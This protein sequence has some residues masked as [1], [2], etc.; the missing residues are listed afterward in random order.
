[1]EFFSAHIILVYCQRQRGKRMKAIKYFITLFVIS[2]FMFSGCG[3]EEKFSPE[4]QKWK[5]DLLLHRA[6]VDSEMLYAPD[7]PFAGLK[8]ISLEAE[9]I[10]YIIFDGGMFFESDEKEAGSIMEISFKD[11]FWKYNDFTGVIDFRSKQ[12]EIEGNVLPMKRVT[13]NYRNYF[14]VLYPLDDRLVFIAFDPERESLKNFKGLSYF[15]PDTIFRVKAK[16]KI[17]EN[18]DLIEMQTSQNRIK[19]YY[20]YAEV[21]FKIKGKAQRLIAYK[22]NLDQPAGKAWLFIPFKDLTT[23]K[24]TYSAGR[25]LEIT[26]PVGE[27]FILDFNYAFN[28]LCNYS[29]VYNCSYP[30]EENWLKISIEAGE[31]SYGKG[32]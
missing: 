24:E 1:M 3:K 14:L 29:H 12:K 21:H 9:G 13:G 6:K 4:L 23:G 27:E 25:F 5:R 10:H 7:S 30:P 19:K 32:H 17:L 22:S 26:E 8:R 11:S 16:L 2:S 15:P 20:R 28:P 31:K 18:P